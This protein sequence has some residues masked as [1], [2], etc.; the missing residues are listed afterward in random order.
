MWCRVEMRLV[1]AALLAEG[2]LVTLAA[3]GSVMADL[4]FRDALILIESGRFE[5]IHLI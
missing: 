1:D 4:F 5:G 2:T 3:L